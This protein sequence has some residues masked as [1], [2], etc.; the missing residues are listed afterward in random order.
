VAHGS[1]RA[2]VEATIDAAAL[3]RRV[4]TDDL[5]CELRERDA[6]LLAASGPARGGSA[7]VRAEIGAE[8]WSQ[9]PWRIDCATSVLPAVAMLE[10][11]VDTYRTTLALNLLVMASAVLLGLFA[12]R[13]TRRRQYLEDRAREDERVRGIERQLFHAERLSTAGRLAAGLAHEINNPLEGLGNYLSLARDAIGSRDL[14]GARRHLDRA[15]EGLVLAAGIVRRVLAHS[16]RATPPFTRVDVGDVLRQSV[17]FVRA[18]ERYRAFE[19]DLDVASDTW[20]RGSPIMLGQV[21][22]NLV[23][24]ACEA[25]GAH[26]SV[27]LAC[28][29]LADTIVAEVADRGPGVAPDE[30]ER[31]FEPFHSSKGSA[32]L[33]LSVCRSIVRDHAGTIDVGDREVGGAVFTVRIPAAGGGD[34]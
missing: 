24:N 13:E 5:R 18:H 1:A 22:L 11:V 33:G 9:S 7:T 4:I 23:L 20:A 10:P 25:Q 32:G 16:E 29:R 28:R 21:F 6:T 3:L 34:G 31:I 26:G 17:D 8:G 19:F 27:R 15:G 14:A 30:R 2:T 12:M